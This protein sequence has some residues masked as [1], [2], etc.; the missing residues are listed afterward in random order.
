MDRKLLTAYYLQTDGLT[1]KINL[2]IKIYLKT[3][4]KQKQKDWIKL[5]LFIQL[6]I[7][8]RK[9]LLIKINLFFL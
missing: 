6:I 1:E 9:A 2:I 8:N 4:V 7:K 3:F 5:C